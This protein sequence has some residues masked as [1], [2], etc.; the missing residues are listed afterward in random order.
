MT[1]VACMT[2]V[3]LVNLLTHH[4][5]WL[6][7]RRSS[8]GNIPL[9]SSSGT[10]RSSS[11]SSPLYEEH[12]V[13]Y[14][15]KLV[16]VAAMSYQSN[17]QLNFGHSSFLLLVILCSGVRRHPHPCR[18]LDIRHRSG[19]MRSATKLRERRSKSVKAEVK[20]VDDNRI[21]ASVGTKA[22]N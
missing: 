14:D 5:T 13:I 10:M 21:E 4:T 22:R 19:I 12:H 7:Q 18:K 15:S 11:S 16:R 9:R 3:S 20:S 8:Q 17:L 2:D 1:I 6:H